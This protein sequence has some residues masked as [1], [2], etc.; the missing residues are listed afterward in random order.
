[1][2][3]EM[4]E[5]PGLRAV[6]DPS[7]AQWLAD[8]LWPRRG[9]RAMQVGA[10]VPDVYPSYGRLLHPARSATPG[11][12]DKIRWS[13][14]SSER[15]VPLDSASRFREL[16]GWDDGPVPPQPYSAPLRGS[17]D[18]EE[19]IALAEV[20][21]GFTSQPEVVWYCLWDGYGWPELPAP[22]QG[23]PRVHLDHEDC[24]LF[25]GPLEASA[26]FQSWEWFQ[27]PTIWWPDDHAWCV[28][29]PVDGFSTYIG[30]TEPCLNMLF[31]ERRL[32]V[33]SIQIDQQIDPS[34][35]LA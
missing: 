13:A 18:E 28:S 16:T 23:P 24:L 34:P 6:Y 26:N 15:G 27:S 30:G 29:T 17:L 4:P 21:A 8:G 10:V 35:Y 32:E 12:P 1:M 14:I 11:G 3:P 19:C 22:G 7:P 20:L 33:L 2:S 5:F 9:R 31:R 25:T